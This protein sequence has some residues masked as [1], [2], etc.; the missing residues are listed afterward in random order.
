MNAQAARASDDNLPVGE[1]LRRTR[2]YYSQSVDDVG[3]ILRIRSAHLEAIE[4]GRVD[5]LPGRVYAFGFVRAYA[6][7][8]GLDG[9]QIVRL[10]KS[11]IGV[12]VVDR[13]DLHM[14]VAASE[15][16]SPNAAIVIGSLAFLAVAIGGLV[17]WGSQ[18]Q[19]NDIAVA[20]VHE[21]P[22]V[23]QEMYEDAGDVGPFAPVGAMKQPQ[24]VAVDQAAAEKPAS[25]PD[26]VTSVS[27]DS[28]VAQPPLVLKL[29]DSAWVEIRDVTGKALLSRILKP[30]DSY[31][32]PASV[33]GLVLDT[34]NVGALEF[35]IGNEVFAPLG[36]KG[37]V[38]RGIKMDPDFL[39][40]L[41][42]RNPRR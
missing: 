28:S 38:R 23:P 35:S 30:G 25:V 3:A 11:Q 24:S 33:K 4:E 39:R 17:F 19:V 18:R 2:V 7:Y 15:S 34:G 42:K 22:P 37:D 14:P 26:A 21:I 12:Q 32:V 8:L 41:N 10:F 31:I 29:R 9:E 36:E 6:E 16:K 1:I 40:D 27:V 5:D 20:D 13:P